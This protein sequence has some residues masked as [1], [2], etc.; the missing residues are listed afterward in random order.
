[1]LSIHL[2]TNKICDIFKTRYD[3]FAE[4]GFQF[5]QSYIRACWMSVWQA[6]LKLPPMYE[7]CLLI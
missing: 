1:M 5:E 6:K 2:V 7:K 4:R 3:I